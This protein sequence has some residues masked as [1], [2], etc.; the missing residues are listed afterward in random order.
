MRE[1]IL[2]ALKYPREA[3]V[4]ETSVILTVAGTLAYVFS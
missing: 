3:L 2:W 4:V 1:Y